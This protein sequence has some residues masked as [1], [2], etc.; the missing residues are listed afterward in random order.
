MRQVYLAG[1]AKL[2]MMPSCSEGNDFDGRIGL[3]ISSIFVIF[4]GSAL[5]AIVP[6][7]TARSRSAKDLKIPEH[8]FFVA[9]YFGSGVILATALIHVTFCLLF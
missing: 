8:V 5:G 2:R 7:Y 1:S 9:R 6:V 3:R 4:V